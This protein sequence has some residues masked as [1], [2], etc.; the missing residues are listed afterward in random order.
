MIFQLISLYNPSRS[1]RSSDNFFVNKTF[2]SLTTKGPTVDYVED[3]QE[4]RPF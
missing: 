4:S 3:T 2:N 1:L